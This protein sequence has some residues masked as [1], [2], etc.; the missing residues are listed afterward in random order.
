MNVA[1]RLIVAGDYNVK[2]KGEANEQTSAVVKF[3][4][5]DLKKQNGP[6]KDIA[7]VFLKNDIDFTKNVG[8]KPVCLPKS[9]SDDPA[10]EKT[11]VVTGWGAL[12]SSKQGQWV[13][14]HGID[15]GLS[16]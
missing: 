15:K 7:V 16:T 14:P 11:C 6:Y 1:D 13:I 2:V 12:A 9:S 3:I 8:A 5:P 10:V 4:S